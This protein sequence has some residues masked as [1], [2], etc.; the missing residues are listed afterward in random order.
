[1]KNKSINMQTGFVVCLCALLCC[2]LWGSAFPFIKIG[3]KVFEISK[4][5]TATQILFAGLRF[6][7]A[8][9]MVIMSGCV[10][11]FILLY[12]PRL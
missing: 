6:S 2:F 8:G 12:L 7:L 3:Y 9:I 1:M 10:T 11:V 5:D 4:V